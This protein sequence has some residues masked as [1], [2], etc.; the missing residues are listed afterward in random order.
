MRRIEALETL[1]DLEKCAVMHNGWLLSRK[2]HRQH[3][4]AM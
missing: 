3:V 2:T 4:Q 1:G